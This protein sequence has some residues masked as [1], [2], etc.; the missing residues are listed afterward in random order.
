MINF[1]SII[2]FIYNNK[3]FIFEAIINV[4][5]LIRE[6]INLDNSIKVLTLRNIGMATASNKNINLIKTI[7]VTRIDCDD[8]MQKNRIE[9]QLTYINNR[10]YFAVLN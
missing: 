9:Q 5:N 7:Y 6:L 10:K 4:L 2:I 1:I 3:K 8:V